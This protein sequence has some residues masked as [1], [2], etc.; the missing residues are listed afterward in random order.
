VVQPGPGGGADFVARPVG[1]GI[2]V[3][4]GQ[5]VIVDNRPAGVI[6]GQI[7]SRARPDGYTLLI[8]GNSFWIAPLLGDNTPFDPVKDFAA[9]TTAVS[10]PHILVIHP[11][12]PATSV[13]ELIAVAKARPG[14][15]NSGFA[16]A[17]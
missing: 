15:L 14:T 1:Q 7:V 5:Q 9:I 3:P 2:S 4:L 11:P 10:T 6:P 16:A 13:T 17:G 12:F 8:N